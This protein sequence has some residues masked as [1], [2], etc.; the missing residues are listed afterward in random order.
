MGSF[1]VE[2]RRRNR[3][4]YIVLDFRR[5]REREGGREGERERERGRI[6]RDLGDSNF[7]LR[8]P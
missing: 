2:A 4:V 1:L 7:N 6:S 3:K 5:E 8:I